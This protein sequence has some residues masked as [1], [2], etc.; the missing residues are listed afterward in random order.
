VQLVPT[1]AKG[2]RFVWW[3]GDCSGRRACVVD[4]DASV[5]AFF[6]HG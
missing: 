1:A 5:T 3:G 6:R 4:N 2:Y